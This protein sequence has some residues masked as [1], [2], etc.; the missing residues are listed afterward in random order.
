MANLRVMTS[1]NSE[2]AETN[3][4]YVNP[5]DATT[6]FVKMGRFIYKC[7]PHPDVEVGTVRMNAVARRAVYPNETVSLEEFTVPLTYGTKTVSIRAEYLKSKPGTPTN[8]VN[9]IRTM[10]DG[11]IVSI[12][13]KLTIT[14]EGVAILIE[15]TDMDAPGVI[16]MNTEV[17]MMWVPS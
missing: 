16:T 4:L 8:L 13:Q 11:K 15:V 5:R 2:L 17:S 3:A 1:L 9:A 12:G 14:H 7:I 10:L 6:P